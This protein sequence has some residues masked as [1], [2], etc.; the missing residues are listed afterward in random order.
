MASLRSA[1]GALNI[2][3]KLGFK[4]DRIFV[5]V[6]QVFEGNP[7]SHDQIEKVIHRSVDM[8]IPYVPIEFVRAINFGVP[9]LVKNPESPISGL[10]EDA[11]YWLSND[12]HKNIPPAAPTASW[13]RVANRLRNLNN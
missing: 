11:G 12:I 6:N 1:V 5:V 8:S 13:R 3:A 7:L 9:F 2:Y 4:S 10:F